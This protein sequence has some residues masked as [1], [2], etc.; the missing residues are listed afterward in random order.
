ML[1]QLKEEVDT[2]RR[3]PEFLSYKSKSPNGF[4]C[5]GFKIIEFLEKEPWQIDFYCPDRKVMTTFILDKQVEMKETDQIATSKEG[6]T[7]LN[8]DKVDIEFRDVLEKIDGILKEKYPEHKANK[9]IAILQNIEGQE[10]WNV[11]YLTNQFHVLN[12]RI[13]AETGELLKEMLKPVISF[14]S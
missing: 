9:I 7:E 1:E 3:T 4:L 2:L 14:K 13:N 10:V 5:A 8:L 12:V 11:T 6:V